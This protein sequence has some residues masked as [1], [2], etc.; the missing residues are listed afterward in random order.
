[1]IRTFHPSSVRQYGSWWRRFK[2]FMESNSNYLTDSSV[3]DLNSWLANV[4]TR[5]SAT[6]TAQYAALADPLWFRADI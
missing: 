2:G 4:G 5:A 3:L 6:I 1:M